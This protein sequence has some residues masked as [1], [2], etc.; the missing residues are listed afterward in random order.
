[1][2]INVH[3]L[4]GEEPELFALGKPSYITPSVVQPCL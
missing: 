2:D 3:A 4:A 1:M